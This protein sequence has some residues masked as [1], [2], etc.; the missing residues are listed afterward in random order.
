MCVH[1]LARRCGIADWEDV[2]CWRNSIVVAQ[3]TSV[4]RS[5]YLWT[6]F[7]HVVLCDLRAVPV[8]DTVCVGWALVG[9]VIY[10]N[11]NPIVSSILFAARPLSWVLPLRFHRSTPV[12]LYFFHSSIC[13]SILLRKHSLRAPASAAC[14]LRSRNIHNINMIAFHVHLLR[15][16]IIAGPMKF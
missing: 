7:L 8:K 13:S 3:N 11:D 10:T 15:R 14:Y 9:H 1:S 16:L 4:E 12:E 5:V 2:V 6:A